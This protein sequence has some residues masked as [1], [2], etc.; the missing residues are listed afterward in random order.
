M[1]NRAGCPGTAVTASTARI[2]TGVLEAT[3][4]DPQVTGPGARLKYGLVSQRSSASRAAR[5]QPAPSGPAPQPDHPAP[6]T[7]RQRTPARHDQHPGHFHAAATTPPGEKGLS[8]YPGLGFQCGRTYWIRGFTAFCRRGRAQHAPR[9]RTCASPASRIPPGRPADVRHPVPCQP[10]TLPEVVQNA[11]ERHE[12][13]IHA[14]NGAAGDPGRV[15]PRGHH[16]PSGPRFP[17]AP[18]VP[19]PPPGICARDHG[20]VTLPWSG[21]P[22]CDIAV[23]RRGRRA[24]VRGA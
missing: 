13:G 2:L 19:P 18:S 12:R 21:A 4:S 5:T 7:A 23:V 20:D 10:Q 9:E 15:G 1:G 11:L 8:G 3:E 24:G 16:A 14:V 22:R 6:A 17:H